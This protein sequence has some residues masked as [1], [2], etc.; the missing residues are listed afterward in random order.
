MEEL[1]R[2]TK[3]LKTARDEL[4]AKLQNI[5]SEEKRLKDRMKQLEVKKQQ[6]AAANGDVDASDD[7]LIEINAGG[8]IIAARR[9]VLCQLKGTR[10]E[11]LLSGRWEQKLQRDGSGRIFLMSTVIAFKPL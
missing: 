5:G 8:K 2:A 3:R 10:F 4:N 7:D 9:G 11:A 1:E 6:C